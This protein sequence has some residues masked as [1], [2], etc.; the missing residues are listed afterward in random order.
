MIVAIALD[1]KGP[2][3]RTGLLEG[4]A[5]AEIL[6]VKDAI[7]TLTTKDEFKDKGN[8]QH[9]WLDYKNIA[10]VVDI[11]KKIFIDDGLLSLIVK[12]VPDKETIVCT[13]ENGGKLGSRKGVNLPNTNVDL[14][15]VS[16][17]DKADLLFGVQQKV[18]MIFASFIRDGAAVRQIREILGEEGKNIKI[19]AKV[20]NHQGVM[21]IDQII[22]EADG[23]MVA[24]GDLGIE[25]PAEKVVLAQKMIIAK[26]N[27]AGKSVICATQMLESMTDKPRPTRAEANDVANAVNDGADC[28]MLSGETAKGAYPLE[29]VT[30]MSKSC[31]EAESAIYHKD[32][33]H[34]LLRLVKSE[35]QAAAIAVAGVTAAI[36]CKAAAIICL[37]T[38]GASARLISQYRPMC[39]I[40]AVGRYPENLRSLHLYSGIYPLVDKQ[41]KVED[42]P[43]DVDNR[44]NFAINV[45]KKRRFIKSGDQIVLITGWRKGAGFTNTLRVITAP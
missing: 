11:G 26:C 22:A 36:A 25:I 24:R 18:D 7:I 34:D 6:L 12:E 37:T 31:L 21:N 29:A 16:E 45:G 20:E 39:P 30:F 1:T 3:I 44:I 38:T 27:L 23:V 2:E 43:T 40:L 42:W 10:S 14:P 32:Y 13:V 9:I 33:F 15:A 17:K 5:S 41:E 35:S 19:I 4:G 28:V 8:L